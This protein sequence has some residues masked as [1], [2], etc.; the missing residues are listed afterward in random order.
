MPESIKVAKVGF[1]SM[2]GLAVA[3]T[4]HF[5]HQVPKRSKRS[6]SM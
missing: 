3:I 1:N 2:R 6:G 4:N 5:S